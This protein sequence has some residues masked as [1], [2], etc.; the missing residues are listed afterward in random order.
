M[1]SSMGWADPSSTGWVVPSS[2]VVTMLMAVPSMVVASMTDASRVHLL[3]GEEVV[4]LVGKGAPSGKAFNIVMRAKL[5]SY[6]NPLCGSLVLCKGNNTTTITVHILHST[7]FVCT[8]HILYPLYRFCMQSTNSVFT[9]Q[10]LYKP[11]MRLENHLLGWA[12]EYAP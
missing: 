8:I 1:P 11:T 6:G 2:I 10:I 5:R 9:L 3:V 12:L 7:N 4:F